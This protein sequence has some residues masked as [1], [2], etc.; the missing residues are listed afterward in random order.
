M[1]HTRRI[2][3]VSSGKGGVGKTTFAV[4]YALSLA[5]HGRT[6]LIDLDTGTSSVRSCIDTPVPRDLY[7]FF[8]KGQRLADCVT[9][10]DPRLDPQGHFANFGF[11]A[12]PKHM[13]EDITNFDRQRRG[14]LIDAINELEADFVVLDLKAGLDENVIAFLPFSNSGILVFTPHLP[15]ATLAASDIVKAIL[16]RKLRGLFASGSHLYDNL[17]GITPTFVNELLDRVE[18][19]YD[20][21]VPN[22]DAFVL[23]LR[24]ALGDHP[25]VELVGNAVSSFV[26]H[27][28]LNLFNGVADSFDSAVKPFMDNLEEHVSGRL[29]VFNLGWIVAHEEITRAAQARVPALLYRETRRAA[30]PPPHRGAA[31]ELDKLASQYL[32][33]KHVAPRAVATS[34]RKA[35]T[36]SAYLDAQLETLQRMYEGLQGVGFR[37]NFNYVAHRSLHVLS[38]RRIADFGATRIYKD[39]ELRLAFK[40]VKG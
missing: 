35:S 25:V 33:T 6:V 15:A 18:D 21:T 2:I 20:D 34:A 1:R 14:L 31:L 38:S 11:V 32:G 39:D 4:N 29:T 12:G 30:A 40:L 24:H 26:V 16:F 37:D 36:A 7:H 5:R 28:V 3:P 27:Y 13:I 19:V 17:R 22:L 10:L 8:K 9:A 23:D